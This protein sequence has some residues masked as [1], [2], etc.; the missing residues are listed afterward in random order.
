M[1]VSSRLHPITPSPFPFS[2]PTHTPHPLPSPPST[3]VREQDHARCLEAELTPL[4]RIRELR[5]GSTFPTAA[6]CNNYCAVVLGALLCV[7]LSVCRSVGRSVCLSV[8]LS[9]CRSVC[10]CG[11]RGRAIYSPSTPRRALNA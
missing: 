9:V 7:C 5:Q 2:P 11:E 4:R 10:A 8:G 6:E 3:H 1:H